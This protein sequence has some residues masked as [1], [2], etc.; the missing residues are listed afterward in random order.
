MDIFDLSKEEIETEI[1]KIL[2]EYTSEELL[3]K[4]KKCGL[5]VNNSER[6]KTMDKFKLCYIERNKAW[7]TDSFENQSRR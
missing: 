1:D 4:L 3:E 7:F 5:T 6:G 2:N